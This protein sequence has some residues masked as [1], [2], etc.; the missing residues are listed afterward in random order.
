[1]YMATGIDNTGLYKGKREAMGIIKAMAGE[2]TS[3]DVFGGIGISA[4]ATF[5]KA[6]TRR[7][8]I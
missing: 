7:I 8:Y 4:A 2:V 6:A 1:M 5:A 3:F